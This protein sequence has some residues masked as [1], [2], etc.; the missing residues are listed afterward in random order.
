M[1]LYPNHFIL[2]SGM[3]W[4]CWALNRDPPMDITEERLPR[5]LNHLSYYPPYV[6]RILL[7]LSFQSPWLVWLLL[8]VLDLR[9]SVNLSSSRPTPSIISWDQNQPC[10]ETKQIETMEVKYPQQLVSLGSKWCW[11]SP[12][13][14]SLLQK[15]SIWMIWDRENCLEVS[16][17]RWEL[18]KTMG[19]GQL[20]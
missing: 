18:H 14:A 20:L 3:G 15:H 2:S 7:F 4:L 17:E 13:I 11:E 12:A 5:H 10:H 1:L 8:V 9:N 19:N 6:I 16:D